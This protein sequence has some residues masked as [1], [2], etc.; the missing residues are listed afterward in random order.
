MHAVV[1]HFDRGAETQGGPCREFAH[2]AC[3]EDDHFAGAHP[4]DPTQHVPHALLAGHEFSC[5]EDGCVAGD[6][7]HRPDQRLDAVFVLNEVPR[8]G[9]GLLGAEGLE[10]AFV[11]NAQLQGRNEGLAHAHQGDLF[12]GGW[13]HLEHNAGLEDLTLVVDNSGAGLAVIVVRELGV[14]SGLGF[15][16]H[17]V[18]VRGQKRHRFRHKG[19]TLFLQARFRGD[20]DGQ[21]SLSL[22]GLEQFLLWEQGGLAGEGFDGFASSIHDGPKIA[23]PNRFNPAGPTKCIALCRRGAPQFGANARR[24]ASTQARAPATPPT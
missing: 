15:H 24:R 22:L 7:A 14:G 11:L 1:E 12:Q 19:H 8:N 9:R 3:T 2:S 6:F 17:L 23:K 20:A 18:T 5:N 21:L 16:Q 4:A 13:L 10:Q